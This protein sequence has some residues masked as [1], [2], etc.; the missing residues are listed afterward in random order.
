[1]VRYLSTKKAVRS[2]TPVAIH[3][4]RVAWIVISTAG[5]SKVYHLEEG[6]FVGTSRVTRFRIPT[7]VPYAKR[8]G[9]TLCTRCEK[10]EEKQIHTGGKS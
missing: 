3:P 10:R 1:M 6:C 9:F 8:A 2:V 5:V 4:A 7:L